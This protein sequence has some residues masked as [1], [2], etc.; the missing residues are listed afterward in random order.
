MDFDWLLSDNQSPS[1]N[2]VNQSSDNIKGELFPEITLAHL[3]D[4]NIWQSTP[5]IPRTIIV[6]VL[7]RVLF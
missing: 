7:D 4:L 6:I 1:F 2:R 3:R 5:L